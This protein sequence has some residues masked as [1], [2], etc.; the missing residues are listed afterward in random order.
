MCFGNKL[1]LFIFYF[2]EKLKINLASFRN[3]S[4]KNDNMNNVLYTGLSE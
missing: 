2:K 4:N 3:S 1:F